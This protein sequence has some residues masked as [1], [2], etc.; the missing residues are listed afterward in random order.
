[1]CVS[2]ICML[3]G[4]L[5]RSLSGICVA[6]VAF[7]TLCTC[8]FEM[9]SV[10]SWRCALLV[11]ADA[12]AGGA[13]CLGCAGVLCVHYVFIVLCL[14]CVVYVVFGLCLCRL[15][16]VALCWVCCECQCVVCVVC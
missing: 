7:G 4:G 9:F 16:Y 10:Y 2:S 5:W 3:Y 15:L 1:M 11:A 12:V 13:H 14:V 8:V 6:W